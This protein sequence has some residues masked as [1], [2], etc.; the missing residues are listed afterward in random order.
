MS[1]PT[2][3]YKCHRSL[4]VGSVEAMHDEDVLPQRVPAVHI[5]QLWF[6]DVNPL[7]EGLFTE[8]MKAVRLVPGLLEVEIN[9]FYN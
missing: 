1:L 4:G 7:L 9:L 8:K 3:S 6:A 2:I 5:E